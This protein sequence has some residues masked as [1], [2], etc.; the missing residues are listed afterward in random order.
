MEVIRE[1]PH[2]WQCVCSWVL[3]NSPLLSVHKVCIC[4]W[5]LVSIALSRS[6]IAFTLSSLCFR[7]NPKLKPEQLLLMTRE[8]LACN[9]QALGL[10]G[11]IRLAWS[12][13]NLY[14]SFPQK[15]SHQSCLGCSLCKYHLVEC[16]SPWGPWQSWNQQ[17]SSVGSPQGGLIIC[18]RLASQLLV[19]PSLWPIGCFVLKVWF[20]SWLHIIHHLNTASVSISIFFMMQNHPLHMWDSKP[21]WS[22]T[23]R[24][25]IFPS[26]SGMCMTC[27]SW[28]LVTFP[29]NSKSATMSPLP[30]LLTL[31]LPK[32]LMS[33]VS[34]YA[35]YMVKSSQFGLTCMV[36]AESANQM[37]VHLV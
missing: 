29:W 19:N 32:A 8:N 17:V 27:V 11:P 14:L 20:S 13:P 24:N 2:S 26:T 3:T 15:V 1:M 5:N 37:S 33:L 6:M 18:A 31:V 16:L 30:N 23:L 4:L 10:I 36:A 25:K 9:H 22:K 21:F 7:L 28:I 12:V 35:W 34:V